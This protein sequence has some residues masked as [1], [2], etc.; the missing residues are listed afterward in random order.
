M[1]TGIL[2]CGVRTEADAAQALLAE[3]LDN[4]SLLLRTSAIVGLGIA[5][6]GS[7]REDLAS[8]LLPLV[9]DEDLSMEIASLT[10]LSLGFIFVGSCHGEI[11]STILQTL[12]ERDSQSL[13]QKWSRFM[14]LGLALLYLG[15]AYMI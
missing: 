11:T 10:A 14:V 3:Y 2:N 15:T 12:M 6:A 1:A 4:K 8:M 5:Y 7:Q 13:D 9:S